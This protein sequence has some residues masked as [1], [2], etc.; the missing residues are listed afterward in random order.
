MQ[1]IN[2]YQKIGARLSARPKRVAFLVDDSFSD[3]DINNLLRYCHKHLGGRYNPIVPAMADGLSSSAEK[4]L[5]SIDPDILYSFVQ[6]DIDCEEKLQRLLRPARIIT[7]NPAHRNANGWHVSEEEIRGIKLTDIALPFKKTVLSTP[8]CPQIVLDDWDD[9]SDVDISFCL[10]NFGAFSENDWKAF[11]LENN[12]VNMQPVEKIT[13]PESF[14]ASMLPIAGKL[15]PAQLSTAGCNR[16]HYRCDIG[17]TTE[18][19]EI[20]IGDSLRDVLYIWNRS[21]MQGFTWRRRALWV[22][23]STFKSDGMVANIASWVKQCQFQHGSANCVVLSYS[24]SEE[25]LR[26]FASKL[27]P[28]IHM[29]ISHR[30]LQQDEAC[31]MNNMSLTGCGQQSH[32]LELG[33]SD[34]VFGFP[35]PENMIASKISNQGWVVE[36]EFESPK[37][38]ISSIFKDKVWHLPPRY[39]LDREFI[40]DYQIGSRVA[41]NGHLV[42]EVQGDKRGFGIKIPSIKGICDALLIE[43]RSRGRGENEVLKVGKYRRIDTSSDGQYFWSI[44]RLFGN[45]Q[46]AEF[47]FDDEGW[48]N[49]LYDMIGTERILSDDIDAML[50]KFAQQPTS[51]HVRG[52]SRRQLVKALT[53]MPNEHRYVHRGQILKQLEKAGT[54]LS[55]NE[56]DFVDGQIHSYLS[57]SIFLQGADTRC[58]HCGSSNWFRIDDLKTT[59]TCQGCSSDFAL[60][61]IDSVS[62]RLNSLITNGVRRLG[63]LPVFQALFRLKMLARKQLLFLPQQDLFD[64]T[65]DEE[66]QVTDLD[67]VGVIDGKYF[68]GEVKS[69]EQGLRS[70]NIDQFEEIALE[71][72][73]DYVIVAAPADAFTKK[74]QEHCRKLQDKLKATKIRTDFWPLEWTK[75]IHPTSVQ[76]KAIGNAENE[77]VGDE[78]NSLSIEPIKEPDLESPEV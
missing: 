76:P 69:G 25:E 13:D 23:A 37:D 22:P 48:R 7:A 71:L 50:E 54:I 59:M 74:A 77:S 41:S 20:V 53:E 29:R 3:R 15:Y 17:D 26:D 35:S 39:R 73:P 10:R 4:L 68:I 18:E 49:V 47:F 34:T 36:I 72:E 1:L 45:L 9:K 11:A 51:G 38:G 56:G 67:L 5:Q 52:K 75:M 32:R 21:I 24:R 30:V 58:Y 31:T 28:Q 60:Q 43:P 70:I 62:F 12:G 78:E 57:K 46:S 44:L 66:K 40:T 8:T 65:P 27:Q 63:L 61:P 14:F 64:W 55:T 42:V 16:G 6:L 19:Y 2:E 33:Q